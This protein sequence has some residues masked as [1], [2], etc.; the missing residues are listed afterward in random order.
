MT[1][2]PQRF[3]LPAT[4]ALLA[5]LVGGCTAND[6]DGT[7]V[8]TSPSGSSPSGSSG[9]VPSPAASPSSS[10]DSPG[11]A[12]NDLEAG[13]CITDT[14]TAAE[15][16]IEVLPCSEEHGFE[17]FATTKLPEG[18]YPGIGE[19]DALTQEFCR[20]EFTGFV[21]IEYDASELELQYF[22]P[23]EAEWDAEGGRTAVCTVGLPGGNPTTGS[24]E[25]SKR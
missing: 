7:T 24:L 22:F 23:V 16:N 4:L 19:A 21:G 9:E 14:G 11:T 1:A 5:A 18:E 15:P 3:M 12:T 20:E 8:G 10:S 25:G 13:D 17:V 2:S 6:D